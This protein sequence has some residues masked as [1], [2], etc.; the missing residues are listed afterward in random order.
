M[1][2]IPLTLASAL[3]FGQDAAPPSIKVDIDIVNILFNVRDKKSGLVGNLEKDAFTVFEDGK[4]QEIKYFSRETDQPLTIGQSAD[5]TDR[6]GRRPM[7]SP[8]S[9]RRP[10]R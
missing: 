10:R 7:R 6:S 8:G 1:R 2:L 4:Q 9:D 5:G 3:L